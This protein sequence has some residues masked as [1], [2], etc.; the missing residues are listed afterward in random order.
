MRKTDAGL[1][2]DHGILLSTNTVCTL[3]EHL[4]FYMAQTKGIIL[5]PSGGSVFL[6][7]RPCSAVL[8]RCAPLLCSPTAQVEGPGL[9]GV[10]EGGGGRDGHAT[11]TK[12]F[13]CIHNIRDASQPL[14]AWT[15][16]MLRNELEQTCVI[17]AT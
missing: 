5:L 7:Q 15:E 3:Y 1:L 13:P 14:F 12:E 9:K 4:L 16:Q 6:L 8:L 17:C 10:K 2:T 11:S